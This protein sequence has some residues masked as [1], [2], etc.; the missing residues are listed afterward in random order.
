MKVRPP[1]H[2]AACATGARKSGTEVDFKIVPSTSGTCDDL[3]FYRGTNRLP[4]LT[5]RATPPL[6]YPRP[7]TR[8]RL[9]I[10]RL[11]IHKLFVPPKWD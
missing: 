2:Y 5:L 7:G 11:L 6:F 3:S 1:R 8:P 10:R 9:L 4:R